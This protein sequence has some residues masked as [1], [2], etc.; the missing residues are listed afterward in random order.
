MWPRP[1]HPF[2]YKTHYYR[3]ALAPY[4]KRL[5]SLQHFQQF[6]EV[7]TQVLWQ[8]TQY[9]QTL[10][11]GHEHLVGAPIDRITEGRH[12]DGL[13]ILVAAL[14]H[15]FNLWHRVAAFCPIGKLPDIKSIQ[16]L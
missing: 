11:L 1:L 4:R 6:A 9:E 14:P 5:K 13:R 10:V 2:H 7:D 8:L 12:R 15:Q 3:R 16:E